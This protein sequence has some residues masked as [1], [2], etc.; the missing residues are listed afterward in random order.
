MRPYAT[1][2]D[3][4]SMWIGFS[5]R[6]F[7]PFDDLRI[8]WRLRHMPAGGRALMV[9]NGLSLLPRA[10]AH[11]GRHAIAIDLSRVATDMTAQPEMSG[12]SLEYWFMRSAGSETSLLKKLAADGGSVEFVCGDVRDETIAPGP[13]DLIVNHKAIQGLPRQDREAVISAMDARLSPEGVVS[14]SFVNAEQILDE[15]RALFTE[16][17]YTINPDEPVEGKALFTCL[18]TG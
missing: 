9:G 5:R 7:T 12:P 4:T 11:T 14:I 1:N 2:L 13:F 18:S 10:V 17:G 3:G 15:A 16:L 6:A 8:L